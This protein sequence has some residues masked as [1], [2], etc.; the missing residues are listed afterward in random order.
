MVCSSCGHQ[1]P[2]D[3]RFCGM[4]GIR[5]LHSQLSASSVECLETA[6]EPSTHLTAL[7]ANEETVPETVSTDLA[8]SLGQEPASQ[9]RAAAA[10]HTPE[11]QSEVQV[12]A[13]ALVIPPSEAAGP[14]DT[15]HFPWMD[16]VLEQVESELAK[17]GAGH[18]K[19]GFLDGLSFAK[20][21]PHHPTQ[22]AV[23]PPTH[24][25]DALLA[26]AGAYLKEGIKKLRGRKRLIWLATAAVVLVF[27]GLGVVQLLSRRNEFGNGLLEAVKQK[28]E[29]LLPNHEEDAES[30]Q[31]KTSDASAGTR[32]SSQT[33]QPSTSQAASTTAS[34]DTPVLPATSTNNQATSAAGP[35]TGQTGPAATS[36]LVENPQPPQGQ[37]TVT[38][39]KPVPGKEEMAQAKAAHD[40]AAEGAWLWKATAKGNPDAPLQLADLYISGHG[41]PQ[42]C[43]QAM[44]L[45]KIAAAKNDARACSRLGSLYATGTCVPS[46]RV[47]AYNWLRSAL[48]AD[49]NNRTIQ[50]DRELLWQQMTSEERALAE[51]NQ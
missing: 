19:P 34:A 28:V 21:E 42:S 18:D 37:Q 26:I 3:N 33:I 32:A 48:H 5:L 12:L 20:A 43:E 6:A 4:C 47:K 23:P 2:D 1:N 45:L 7:P 25:P 8:E 9:L 44:V 16:D 27:A 11:V 46:D 31:P 41:V 35:A 39:G 24:R 13:D 14:P 29:E 51:R 50:H 22:T 30:G 36:T 10:N 40:S 49:P 15:P 17:S 38:S